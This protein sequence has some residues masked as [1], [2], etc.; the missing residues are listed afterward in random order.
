MGLG[1]CVVGHIICTGMQ[2]KIHALWSLNSSCDDSIKANTDVKCTSIDLLQLRT[3]WNNVI[4]TAH[5]FSWSA[6]HE[7]K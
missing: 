3:L 6:G 1:R 2:K 7:S 5:I 4:N